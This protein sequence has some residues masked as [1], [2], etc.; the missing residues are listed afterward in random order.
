MNPGT[1]V[2]GIPGTK[3]VHFLV[4]HSSNPNTED[5]ILN[6]GDVNIDKV[7]LQGSD[8]NLP[9]TDLN[10]VEVRVNNLYGVAKAHKDGF[11]ITIP[12]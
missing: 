2:N 7:I 5:G 4:D 6:N 8:E 3:S 12:A 10:I 9:K 11:R 1:S